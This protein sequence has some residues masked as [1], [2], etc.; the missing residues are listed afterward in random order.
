MAGWKVRYN[1]LGAVGKRMPR[2]L[3]KGVVEVSEALTR[4]LKTT[5]WID[6]GMIRRVTT[7][8][9][10]RPLHAEVWIGYYLGHGF[11][12]GFQE[13]GTYRQVARPIVTPTAHQH[14]RQFRME[15]AERVRKACDAR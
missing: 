8:K 15:M 7:E 2:E 5:L 10:I 12:S 14:E 13:F 6:T 3:D 11:Y 1:H 9:D 4:K